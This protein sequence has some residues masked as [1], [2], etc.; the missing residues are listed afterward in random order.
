MRAHQEAYERKIREFFEY[1]VFTG[2][3]SKGGHSGKGDLCTDTQRSRAMM[4][5]EERQLSR[6]RWEQR[7]RPSGPRVHLEPWLHV[8]GN[9]VIGAESRAGPSVR[10]QRYAGLVWEGISCAGKF[11][12]I[13]KTGVG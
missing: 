13:L 7:H 4:K 10:M 11:G 1:T 2:E 9:R 3:R 12:S 5:H 6:Q 8:A